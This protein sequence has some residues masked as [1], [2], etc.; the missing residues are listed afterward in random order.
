LESLV[1]WFFG[2]NHVGNPTPENL[3]GSGFSGVIECFRWGFALFCIWGDPELE[4]TSNVDYLVPVFAVV[5]PFF[6]SGTT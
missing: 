5:L 2:Q 3:Y 6:A 1:F 4:F